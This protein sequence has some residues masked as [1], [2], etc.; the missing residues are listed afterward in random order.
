MFFN[1]MGHNPSSTYCSWS[2]LC[3]SVSL[4]FE[5]PHLGGI[6]CDFL[7]QAQVTMQQRFSTGFI[8]A[9]VLAGEQGLPLS[10][11]GIRFIDVGK[12][13][14]EHREEN[15]WVHPGSITPSSFLFAKL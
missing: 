10:Q 11:P 8:F 12:V 2:L 4:L 14:K 3:C 6:G 1:T 9:I 5:A 13:L 15:T 7:L